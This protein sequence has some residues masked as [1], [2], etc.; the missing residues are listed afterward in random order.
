[1][2]I[3]VLA[4]VRWQQLNPTDIHG[5]P[6]TCRMDS[7]CSTVQIGNIQTSMNEHSLVKMCPFNILTYDLFSVALFTSLKSIN[8][9]YFKVKMIPEPTSYYIGHCSY[10]TWTVF[11]SYDLQS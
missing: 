3:I 7:L 6:S 11:G 5:M 4:R 9:I 10:T 1:M 8:S 2:Y